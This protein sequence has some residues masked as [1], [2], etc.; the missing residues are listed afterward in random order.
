VLERTGPDDIQNCVG[1]QLQR[2]AKRADP[3]FLRQASDKQP[4]LSRS[5]RRAR[6]VHKIGLDDDPLAGNTAFDEF[7]PAEVS[8]RDVSRD[9]AAV[10]T[11]HTMQAQHSNQYRRLGR[12]IVIAPPE[13]SA[14][15]QLAD[16]IFADATVSQEGCL[17]AKQS[18]VVKGLDNRHTETRCD[19]ID[20][21]RD[22]GKGI[23][24]VDYI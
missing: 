15:R 12:G 2:I 9:F 20:R 8:E 4:S 10:C 1:P 16:A 22:H 18:I 5:L 14:Q 21:W 3:L 6:E 17:R 13:N 11:E 19:P 23:V 7:G 24:Y